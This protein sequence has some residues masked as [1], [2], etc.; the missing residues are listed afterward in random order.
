MVTSVYITSPEGE[1]GKSAVAL[2]MLAQVTRR[3]SRVGVFRPVV[4]TGER[5]RVL[6]LLLDHATAD[7]THDQCTGVTYDD[8][9]ADPQAALA[10]IVERFH[11]MSTECDAVV[12]VGSDYTD[13]A[14]PTE[15]TFNATVA[16]NLG[17]P[18]MLVAR[19]AQRT[20]AAIRRVV[21]IAT[22]E[23][24]AHHAHCFAVVINRTDPDALAAVR[25]GLSDPSLNTAPDTMVAVLP[26]DTLLVA[27]TVEQLLHACS[28]TL[29]SG[30]PAQLDR[31]ARGVLVS[32]MTMPNVLER[33]FD[34]AV[35]VSPADRTDVLLGVLAAHTAPTFPSLAAV[36]LNGGFTL[37]PS[38]ERLLDGMAPGLPL[39]TTDLGTYETA[40]SLS[41]VRGRLSKTS[42]RAID[43]ARALF[44]RHVDSDT[45]LDRLDV[46]T[47]DVVTPLMF[48]HRL[49]DR[50]RENRR[51]VVLPEGDDERIL[52]A[53]E[54]LLRRGVADIT[55]LGDADEVR[56]LADRIGVDITGASMQNPLDADLREHL[57]AE[58]TRL[59]SHRGATVEAARDVV[60]DVS[61]CGTMMV[62]TGMVDGMVSGAAH[63][64][65]HTIRPSFEVIRTPPGV[66][67]VSSVFL[68]CMPD[69]VLV[70]GDCA[71]NPDPSAEELA[72]IAISSAHTATVF[73]IEPRVAMLSYSTGTS[74]GGSDVDKVR[75][76]TELVRSQQPDLV[77][78]GPIQYD[79]AVDVSVGQSKLPHSAVAGQATVFIFPDLNT[80]NNTY[81]AVQRSAGAIA[82]G[83]VLQG[84]RAPV[85]DLSRGASVQ[86]VVNTVAITA[87]Q[88]GNRPSFDDGCG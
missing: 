11:Q 59:R 47:S 1:T 6:E 81:K 9:H 82:V 2:G 50:S 15:L 86:D 25:A 69:H 46:T 45:L 23:L 35:V 39:I 48:E 13:V 76:A 54:I 80:G 73:D 18:V 14:A 77:V 19:G 64:T 12:V 88:A 20:R 43:T 3:A 24:A 4:R 65:A 30:E 62:R 49:I 16:A 74:G 42:Y 83:P 29:V 28:G 38:I 56:S 70:Y 78:E 68:M 10:T 17:S 71:V 37:P 36:V 57:A 41:G 53:T 52:R 34:G 79:A 67:V 72:D 66:S 44:E 61:Y 85:N 22:A 5:D 51:H 84:L 33:L 87:I 27:P 60:A 40:A 75:I 55:L 63:T 32:G 58:Y 26:E 8:V 7:L 21:E 31:E